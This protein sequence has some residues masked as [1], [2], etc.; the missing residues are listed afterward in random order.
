LKKTCPSCPSLIF[1][2]C[3][4]GLSMFDRLKTG[5]SNLSV[6]LILPLFMDVAG[7]LLARACFGA[8][9][10]AKLWALL[11]IRRTSI[12]HRVHDMVKEQVMPNF[13]LFVNELQFLPFLRSSRSDSADH[14]V[15]VIPM[16]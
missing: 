2:T 9:A 7:C 12:F 5:L 6:S 16:I 4:R 14:L 1:S 3:L 10:P 13:G 15:G 8:N 11:D